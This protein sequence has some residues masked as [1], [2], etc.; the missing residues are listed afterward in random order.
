M[1]EMT[2]YVLG[3]GASYH[4]GYPLAGD[5]G[6]S[7]IA[8]LK[9]SP[10]QV[11]DQYGA[12]LC[13]LDRIYGGLSGFEQI[14][15]EL[16]DC[17]ATSR[18]ASIAD[19]DRRSMLRNLKVMIPEFFRALREGP[20]PLYRRLAG[21]HMRPDDVV[22]TFN[23]DVACERELKRAGLWE[24]D[25]GYG[26]A[27]GI[28]TMPRSQVR[29][30]K[31]HGS[32]NWLELAFRGQTGFFQSPP[33]LLGDRPII[34]PG[35]FDFLGYRGVRDPLGPLGDRAGAFPA[36]IMP[37]SKKR[38]YSETSFGRELEAFWGSLW[39]AAALALGSADR[40][41]IVGYSMS[42]V[43][44]RARALL[45]ESS[46]RSANIQ[47]FCGESTERISREFAASGFDQVNGVAG[48]RFEDFLARCSVVGA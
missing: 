7:L 41:V 39:D 26:F 19:V 11:N 44:E 15:T 37:T 13:E 8:W 47:I 22:I 17:P 38:F 9:R 32:V 28:P 5:L 46:N 2:A 23:Y 21:L 25:D 35:E 27:L 4:A 3:A 34:L 24:I 30:L 10:N 29:V 20:A 18:A 45:L 48:Q 42:A 33:N 31:L 36:T 6:D 43:D 1:P 12:N 14:L 16:E 40:I